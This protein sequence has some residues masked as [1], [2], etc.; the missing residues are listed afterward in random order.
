VCSSDLA[1]GGE[2]GSIPVIALTANAMKGDR[3]TYMA[4]GMNDY[5]SKPIN[6]DNLVRALSHW[7]G[8]SK[9]EAAP[10]IEP[11]GKTDTTTETILD[12]E[13]L[14]T[15]RQAI[16]EETAQ[17]IAETQAQHA[18]ARVAEIRDAVSSQDLDAITKAAHDLKSTMASFGAL[19]ASHLAAELE[20][21]AR[22]RHTDITQESV[23]KLAHAVSEACDCL[24]QV[25]HTADAAE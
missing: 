21:G 16:G 23:E 3:E 24:E 20:R 9:P 5:L 13:T 6:V 25:F 4:A 1:M 10:Q 14:T 15:L 12:T 18:V 2:L 22:E 8:K 11:A 7:G 19:Q 17:Q